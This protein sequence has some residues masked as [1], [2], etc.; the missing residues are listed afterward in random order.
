M[1]INVEKIIKNALEFRND[2]KEFYNNYRCES[3]K[4]FYD[5]LSKRKNIKISDIEK[6][7][8]MILMR[9]INLSLMEDKIKYL[10]IDYS[11]DVLNDIKLER[12]NNRFSMQSN[13]IF[14]KDC[15]NEFEWRLYKE[16][17][18]SLSRRLNYYYFKYKDKE[19]PIYK[20]INNVDLIYKKCKEEILEEG[21]YN[22]KY[23]IAD[24]YLLFIDDK[25]IAVPFNYS[26]TLYKDA[27]K[28]G[29]CLISSNSVLI[30]MYDNISVEYINDYIT[31]ISIKNKY[32]I[33]FKD[34]SISKI[35]I[36]E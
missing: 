26:V 31:Y 8:N 22:E 5:Y 1:E 17:S 14:I 3:E 24:K 28:L 12:E 21:N 33:Y 15:M 7:E 20:I 32:I 6:K 23:I 11:G 34:G 25:S 29:K 18:Y 9:N 2:I 36:N 19:I 30:K 13:G 16:D 35:V 10:Y 27:E 4:E